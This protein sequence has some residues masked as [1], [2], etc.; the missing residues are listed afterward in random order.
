MTAYENAPGIS[1]KGIDFY[2]GPEPVF[3]LPTNQFAHDRKT[4]EIYIPAIIDELGHMERA[5]QDFLP[6]LKS[7]DDT[8]LFPAGWLHRNFPESHYDLLAEIF[9]GVVKGEP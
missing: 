7:E 3:F 5:A 8:V 2:Q 6:L 9:R 1:M 4:G